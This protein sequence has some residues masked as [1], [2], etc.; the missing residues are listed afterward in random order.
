MD[1]IV[2]T[3]FAPTNIE[4]KGYTTNNYSIGNWAADLGLSVGTVFLVAFCLVLFSCIRA[5]FKAS[6]DK[7]NKR[8]ED[9]W[10]K[11]ICEVDS[12]YDR[13]T[14]SQWLVNGRVTEQTKNTNDDEDDA[15]NEM[16]TF[17]AAITNHDKY[18]VVESI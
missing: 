4:D 16:S 1:F 8:P 2:T 3:T 13:E 7:E 18:I 15:V 5:F 17:F 10:K 14:A 6:A 11:S 12:M 9:R